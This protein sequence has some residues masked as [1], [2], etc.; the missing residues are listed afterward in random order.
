MYRESTEQRS[1]VEPSLA[2]RAPHFVARLVRAVMFWIAQ[3]RFMYQHRRFVEEIEQSSDL[4]ALLEALDLT[5]EQL[6]SFE[7]S[8][9][10]SAELLTRMIDRIHAAGKIST[11]TLRLAEQRCRSCEKWKLCLRFLNDNEQ[12]DG[13]RSFCAN[14]DLFDRAS[15]RDSNKT[16][17]PGTCQAVE[18]PP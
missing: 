17:L 5:R 18:T 14:A 6:K 1:E 2:R 9:L 7:I 4:D 10:A 11:S 13:Y 16:Q 12:T 8:P 3:R 15:S